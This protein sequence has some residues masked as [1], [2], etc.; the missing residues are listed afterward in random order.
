MQLSLK[1]KAP[2]LGPCFG[3][4]KG[5]KNTKFIG[6]LIFLALALLVFM[7]VINKVESPTESSATVEVQLPE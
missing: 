6:I 4:L 5:M 2:V 7:V 1:S 3:I